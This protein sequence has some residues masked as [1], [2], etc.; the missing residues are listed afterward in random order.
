[1][2]FLQQAIDLFLHLDKHLTEITS[3]YGTGTYLIL[4]LIVFCET[5]LVVTPFLP[6]DSLLFAA[7]AIAGL[8]GLDVRILAPLF[9]VAAFLGD[10]V[11][12]FIGSR[13]GRRAFSGNIR[14]IKQSYLE[15]TERFY[16]KHGGNTVIMARFVPIVRT[17]APFVAGIGRMPY[18]R[19]IVYSLVG[20]LLWVGLFV[21]GGYLFGN[22]PAVKQNF[23]FVVLAIIA[24]STAP[25]LI[26]FV[27]SAAAADGM[28]RRYVV[29]GRVQGVGLPVLRPARGASPQAHGVRGEPGRRESRGGGGGGR[30]GT[31]RARTGAPPRPERRARDQCRG[32]TGSIHRDVHH[33]Q[34]PVI[35]ST[36][37]AER[38][39]RTLRAIPDHP[40]PGIVFQDITPVLH[41]G[42]TVRRGGGCDGGAV[43][44]GGRDACRG[45][46]GARVHH[47]STTRNAHRGGV[48]PAPEAGQAAVGIGGREVRARVWRGQ[49]ACAPGCLQGR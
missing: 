47:G 23:S 16:E 20:S 21:V 13:I 35:M 31:G 1:M 34:H 36:D 27:R 40:K 44:R 30:A 38:V 48:H 3:Q 7:G 10:N 17:F 5:G 19:F 37:V 39:R 9:I 2:E 8:G 4:F 46:R 14:F 22:L 49:P 24:I 6:G 33:L 45:D 12:Y 42:A 25:I 15:R 26:E 29:S 18:A 41:N 28:I 43:P 11:N 32:S